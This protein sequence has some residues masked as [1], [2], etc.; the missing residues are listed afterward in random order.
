MHACLLPMKEL[1]FQNSG[2]LSYNTTHFVCRCHP[3]LFM[4]ILRLGELVRGPLPS[5][6]PCLFH[7][8]K[9][10]VLH[11]IWHQEEFPLWLSG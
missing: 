1:G 5:A 9:I 4:W 11:K 10:L 7:L 2:F 8:R 6:L 3:T